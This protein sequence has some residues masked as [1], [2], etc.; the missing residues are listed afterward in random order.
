MGKNFQIL[1]V[2]VDRRRR[3]ILFFVNLA[4][5]QARFGK[6]GLIAHGIL[7]TP[8]GAIEIALVQIK[9]T[10]FDIVIGDRRIVIGD[11]LFQ[12]RGRRL[13]LREGSTASTE[14][15]E[16]QTEGNLQKQRFTLALH[17][18]LGYS[19]IIWMTSD[20]MTLFCMAARMNHAALT[21]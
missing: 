8:D 14:S 4:K 12:R 19:K 13:C 5:E 10:N 2:V 20:N 7:E 16:P 18:D 15:G 11:R 9:L 1:L 21:A 6:I 3:V 17:N